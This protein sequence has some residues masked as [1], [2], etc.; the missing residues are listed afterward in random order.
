M[1]TT[2]I[3]NPAA[4]EE[5]LHGPTGPV[6]R[7]MAGRGEAVHALARSKVRPSRV[8]G[9]QTPGGRAPNVMSSGVSLR[10][11]GIVQYARVPGA[12]AVVLVRFRK[13]YAYFVDQ[14][15]RPHE[16]RPKRKKALAFYWTRLG[17]DVVLKSVNH[18]GYKGSRYLSG[19]IHAAGEGVSAT[20]VHYPAPATD[21]S[22][23]D[24]RG[25]A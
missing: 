7:D 18:P 11:A 19:S 10:D 12:G 9:L 14:G 21:I 3:L 13:H 8:R 15:T 22:A 16:I 2:V 17:T 4:I 5:L 6:M 25:V 24:L 1:P 20:F 23:A